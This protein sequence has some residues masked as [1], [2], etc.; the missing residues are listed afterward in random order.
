MH[1]DDGES[2]DDG[3]N[4]SMNEHDDGLSKVNNNN[5]SNNNS[6][7]DNKIIELPS[8]REFNAF[9]GPN[10]YLNRNCF[11]ASTLSFQQLPGYQTQY[12]YQ[13]PSSLLH[14][15]FGQQQQLQ[16]QHHQ[17]QITAQQQQQQ[18]FNAS[19]TNSLMRPYSN[20]GSNSN[21]ILLAQFQPI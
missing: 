8:T 14:S 15:T 2:S 12:S 13:Y 11:S 19:P 6:T 5:N 17:Q 21:G 3:S 20:I 7:S 4:T 9:S 1:D 16:Q 10:D 18:H